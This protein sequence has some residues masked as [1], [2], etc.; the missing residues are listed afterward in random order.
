MSPLVATI[1][2]IAIVD[3]PLPRTHLSVAT[4]D[5]ESLTVT[6]P[7]SNGPPVQVSTLPIFSVGDTWAFT[8][9]EAPAGLVPAGLGAGLA[10]ISLA[11][12][13]PPYNL[14]GLTYPAEALP[15]PVYLNADASPLGLDATEEIVQAALD[16]WSG[17]GCADFAFTYEG[18]TE[19]RNDDDKLNVLVWETESWEWGG[20]VA[21][22]SATRFGA[23]STGNIVPVGADITFNAVDWSWVDGPGDIYTRPATLNAASIVLHELGHVTGMDHEYAL[24]ASTMFFAYI[25][26][27]WQ[28]TLSGDDRRGLCE[29]YPAGADE[30]STDD[31]CTGIDDQDRAC[32]ELGGVKVCDEVRDA[33]GAFC[34]RTVFNCPEYCVFTKTDATEGYCASSCESDDDC[35]D[36]TICDT[37]RSFLY[38]DPDAEERLCVIGERAPDDTASP[39][40]ADSGG[41]DSG[42]AKDSG[43][44]QHG[45][46]GPAWLGLLALWRR[47]TTTPEETT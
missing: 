15:L 14:N 16:A 36:G 2:A 22:F 38:D 17:V 44:C 20:S 31:D 42:G 23:D 46:L 33:D 19:A 5:G 35:G 29:N 1:T 32:V 24:V 6:V 45:P 10:P 13:P 28:G 37:A 34:S 4:P 27:D 8:L 7:G 41:A 25:G 40:G 47:R 30:C 3:G 39:S 43:R 11:A 9:D 12:P 18:L 26:G 21:G